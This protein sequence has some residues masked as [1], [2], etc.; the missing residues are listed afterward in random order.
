MHVRIKFF[1]I[2]FISILSYGQNCN[3]I[4]FP[5]LKNIISCKP[6][7]FDNGNLIKW[8]YNCSGS[9]L[10]FENNSGQKVLFE[11]KAPLIELT[12]KLGYSNWEEYDNFFIIENRLVS[13]CCDPEEYILFDKNTG[14]EIKNL[15][16]LLYNN[17]IYNVYLDFFLENKISVIIFDK[18]KST[19][20]S[21][22]LSNVDLIYKS[23]E[24][25]TFL[26]AENLFSIKE[27][28]PNEVIIE[29]TIYNSNKENT[30][31]LQVKIPLK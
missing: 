4:T 15:G 27:T 10:I 2:Y 18:T 3:C 11:L 13:G 29:I 16:N 12:G 23:L 28:K 19:Y 26:F 7:L 22:P 14:N 9:Q 24:N 8:N 20:K 5:E 21:Y 1:I 6:Y 25:T 17:S 31:L 30:D